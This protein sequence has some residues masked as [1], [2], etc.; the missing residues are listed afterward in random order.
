[1]S[2]PLAGA[3]LQPN[4]YARVRGAI[5]L[6]QLAV[7][8]RQRSSTIDEIASAMHVT[9]RTAYRDLIALQAVPFPVAKDDD[10]RWR[11]TGPTPLTD[12]RR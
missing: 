1:M 2:P 10:G 9:R 6:L 4:D 8:L 5:R 12:G 11:V 7:M 3:R